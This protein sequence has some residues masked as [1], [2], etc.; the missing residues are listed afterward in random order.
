M[1]NGRL[2]IGA[3]LVCGG[4]AVVAIPSFF[5]LRRAASNRLA[6]AGGRYRNRRKIETPLWAGVNRQSDRGRHEKGPA[7]SRAWSAAGARISLLGWLAGVA[8]PSRRERDRRARGGG[9]LHRCCR[10]ENR[11]Y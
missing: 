4:A 9:L 6:F 10:Q 8:A 5:P 1:M 2:R 7:D 11:G 3:P